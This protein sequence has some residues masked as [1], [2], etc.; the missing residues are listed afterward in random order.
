MNEIVALAKLLAQQAGTAQP[1]TRERGFPLSKRPLV[2]I[3]I[4]MAGESPALFGLGV[5]DGHS[6]VKVYVCPNPINRDE[7]YTMLADA[8]KAIEPMVGHGS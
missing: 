1:I 5:G 2:M 4:V 7:Q 3:P 8:V 6:P